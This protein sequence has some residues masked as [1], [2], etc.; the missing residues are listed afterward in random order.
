MRAEYYD[1]GEGAISGTAQILREYTG[2]F[3]F[4]PV[5]ALIL[6]LEARYDHSSAEAFAGDEVDAEGD[7]VRDPRDQVLFV[8]GAV[9]VF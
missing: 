5:D 2:T 7:A 3:E 4:R 1:D 6:R 9:A 8:A